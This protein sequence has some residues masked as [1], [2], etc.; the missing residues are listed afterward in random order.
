MMGPRG[1]RASTSWWLLPLASLLL[2]WAVASMAPL[3]IPTLTMKPDHQFFYEEEEV[4]LTCSAPAPT[5]GTI[6]TFRFLQP[7]GEETDLPALLFF[8][9]PRGLLQLWA[10]SSSNGTYTCLYLLEEPGGETWSNQS[11]P[12]DIQVH[13]APQAPAF[14]LVPQQLLYAPGQEVQ[15][16]CSVPSSSP[17]LPAQVQFFSTRGLAITIITSRKQNQTHPHTLPGEGL[18]A[19]YSCSY[20]L[21]LSNRLVSSQRSPWVRVQIQGPKSSW[22]R[23]VVVGG[24]FFVINGLIFITSHLLMRR[25]DPAHAEA[26]P[27][28]PASPREG[29]QAHPP[30]GKAPPGSP[31]PSP[32]T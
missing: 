2:P 30:G 29:L 22:I 4:A 27:A 32:S 24:S 10:N 18:S 12:L 7:N 31:G 25:R 28:P 15:L 19:S 1:R 17:E 23:E 16:F 20:F 14:S 9:P 26:P 11:L 3:P 8:P 21:L 13:A 5:R 6:K